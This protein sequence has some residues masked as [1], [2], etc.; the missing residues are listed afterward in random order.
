[1]KSVLVIGSTGMLGSAVGNYF[2]N[3]NNYYTALTYRKGSEQ[4]LNV[5]DPEGFTETI[6]YDPLKDDFNVL[7]GKWDYVINCI[8][9]I[10]P[11]MDTNP[12]AARK[13]NVIFPWVLADW[14]E[15]ISGKLIH[16]TTDCV[17][18]GREGM[19]NENA[20][21]DP[22]DQY[23]KSKSLGEPT[24]AMVLR[25]SI[26]GNEVHNNSSL[27]EWAKSKKNST[28][29]GFKNHFWN[30]ITTNTYAKVVERIIREDMY[31]N[32]LFHVHS[33]DVVSKFTLLHYFN[34]RFG[35]NMKINPIQTNVSCDRSLNS[36]K[37]LNAKLEIPTVRD[38]IMAI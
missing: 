16:I 2:V 4:A 22:I 38:Q 23:G 35:L 37:D 12:L 20:A 36:V 5:V 13:L 8:G 6:Q 15:K 34:E 18:S 14:C 32:G 30:G 17:F 26:V 19:Y 25:T 24:N 33:K 21:H 1:M 10:K 29:D 28:V 27:L 31:E 9:T 11:F 3:N 7:A